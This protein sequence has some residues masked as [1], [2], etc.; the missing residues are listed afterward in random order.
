[1]KASPNGSAKLEQLITFM[2]LLPLV[3]GILTPSSTWAIPISTVF[4]HENDDRQL[5]NVYAQIES[6][7]S[8][9]KLLSNANQNALT[10]F[11]KVAGPNGTETTKFQHYYKGVAVIGSNAFHHSGM[12]GTSI[13]NRIAEFDLDVKPT[14]DQREA[15]SLAKGIA[16]DFIPKGSPN[17][18]ILPSHDQNSARLV[19]W[20]ELKNSHNMDSRDVIIDAHQGKLI[21]NLSRN[22][23]IAPI[24]VYSASKQGLEIIPNVL[25]DKVTG[26]VQLQ[27]C[28]LVQMKDEKITTISKASCLAMYLGNPAILEGQCQVVDGL[29]GT[30]ISIHASECTQVVF[31]GRNT[32]NDDLSVTRANSNSFKVLSYFENHFGRNSYDNKGSDLVSI[33]HGGHQMANAFWA[34]DLHTMVY[35]DGDGK[36]LGDFTIALDV[37]GHEMTHGIT[38]ETANLLMMNE[39]GALNEAFSDYFGKMIEDQDDWIVGRK[40]FSEGVSAM[41]IRNLANPGLIQS[42][43]IDSD[44]N[45]IKR[46]YPSKKA[47]AAVVGPGEYCDST[48]DNCWVHFNSTIP[49]HASYL[50]TQALGKAKAETLY[51]TALTQNLTANDNFQSAAKAIIETCEQLAFSQRECSQVREVYKDLGM[52]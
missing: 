51:Y 46:P 9:R 26:K 4:P 22:Y 41:G 10:P 48:N 34:S 14:L 13:R 5:Q 18:M 3:A 12:K 33:V 8:I 21:A 30:P 45:E 43:L 32:Q 15:I 1:M 40:L 38:A 42:T 52:I 16:G 24:Q 37:A 27:S 11:Q 50:V 47:E 19:Y 6:E 31:G 28:K 20:V 44:G 2:H 49:G 29:S 39:S 35:G 25:E 36:T 17:L 7:P 23:T